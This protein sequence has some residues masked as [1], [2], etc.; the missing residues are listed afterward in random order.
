M[1]WLVVGLGNPGE[2]YSAT[3]HNAGSMVVEA[4][5][6]S[7][8]ERFRKVRFIPVETAE[9]SEGDE[10]LILARPL[11]FMNESGPPVGSLAKRRRV[12]PSRVVVVHDEIDLPF[13]SLRVKL[14]GST[15][16]HQGLN[17]VVSGLRT[18]DFYRVRLGVGRPPGR[19]D[20]ADFVLEPFSKKERGEADVLV[21][22]AADA[23]RSLVRDGLAVAQDRYNR[24]GAGGADS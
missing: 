8:G 7:A 11:T 23:V 24:G 18:P 21:E 6:R 10:R 5:A 2:N 3:R 14:G 4:L 15:A 17:S 16:G 1:T 19:Q 12:D 9:I 20:P 13:G 22:D